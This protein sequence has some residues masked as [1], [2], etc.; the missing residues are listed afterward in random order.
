LSDTQHHRFP[1][2][3]NA[4][5]SFDSICLGCYETVA[6]RAIEAELTPFELSHT[7][8][9]SDLVRLGKIDLGNLLL[10]VHGIAPDL[11]YVGPVAPQVSK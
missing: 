3:A 7:C 2:R 11:P 1:H 10:Y 4:D 8:R 9:T 5:G 6:Q